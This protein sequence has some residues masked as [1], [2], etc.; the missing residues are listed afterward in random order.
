MNNKL[1]HI[2]YNITLGL[3]CFLIV[4]SIG[5][6]T[7]LLFS[8]FQILGRMHPLML[9]FP[10]VLMILAG[11]WEGILRKRVQSAS[12]DSIEE[13]KST[14]DVGEW[15]ILVASFTAALSAIMGI[16]LSKEEG[17]D[18]EAISWHKW[19]GI[20]VSLVAYLWLS[21]LQKIRE[22][23]ALIVFASILSFLVV[24]IAGH[25]GANITHGEGFILKPLKQEVQNVVPINDAV[26][27]SHLVRPILEQKCI[28][29][30][31][32]QKS[33][34][35]LI[36]DTPEGLLKGG[37]NGKLWDLTASHLGL[38]LQRI[39]LPAD[40]KEHMPPIGK[41]QLTDD[42][43]AILYY[44][45]KSGADFNQKVNQLAETDSLKLLAKNTLKVAD[46]D[47]F[48]FNAADEKTIKKLNTNNR[49]VYPIAMNSPAL[50]V[51]F[52][53]TNFFT[54][55]H[56]KELQSI[57]EQIV[58]LNLNKMP[59]KD[60][61]LKTISSFKNLRKL[62]LSF[63][64]ITGNGLQELKNL[65]ELRQLSLSGTVVKNQD[66][67]VLKNLP[68]LSVLQLWNTALTEKDWSDLKSKLPSTYIE[69]GFYGDTVIARLSAPILD[70]EDEQIFYNDTTITLKHYVNGAI[71]RY[72]LDGTDPDSLNSPIY[73]KGVLLSKTSVL[74][75]RAFLNGWVGSD[76]LIHQY[77]KA[78]FIADSVRLVQLPNPQYM[79]KGKILFD[80]KK[81][82]FNFKSGKWLGFKE[83]TFEGLLYFN[84]PKTVSK[85]TISTLVSIG[86]YIM[87]AQRLEIWG[88]NSPDKLTLLNAFQPKQP[89]KI[90]LSYLKGYEMEFKPQSFKVLKVVGKPVSKLPK[91]HPGK[92]D[93]GWFFI[94]EIFL[95]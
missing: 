28:N 35:D 9:H 70:D 72:T 10:I 22:S 5:G 84:E 73:D 59:I 14:I 83:T 3:N 58:R 92:G 19:T 17:Y 45:I 62:N 6:Q 91:W 57:K 43:K 32:P 53:G 76:T 52:F 34:G 46:S 54:S 56:L 78:G 40:A 15:I 30:H 13:P 61:D 1:V 68:R 12:F 38:L 93:K 29:C 48:T 27:Y 87:P 41:P 95:N 47:K 66:L 23:S 2:L 75:A 7:R 71:I 24:V 42:E 8:G 37:K 86:S 11:I 31:N 74:K 4:V 88:G 21:F 69:K 50:S 64:Q 67:D 26:V 80:G 20:A 94:D 36:M 55:Q 25:Q 89:T 39:H 18:L 16:F 77:Y 81:G 79:G 63:T 49:I 51:E 60:E 33:K 85:I 44:W 65:K 82:D 90:E